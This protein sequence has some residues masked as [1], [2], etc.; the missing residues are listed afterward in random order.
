MAEVIDGRKIAENVGEE[1]IDRIKKLEEIGIIPGLAV[2]VVGDRPDTLSYVKM[3]QQKAAKLGIFFRLIQFSI[4]KVSEKELLDEIDVLNEN[5]EIHGIIVQLPLPE[6]IDKKRVTSRISVEKDVDGFHELNM[7]R[8]ALCGYTPNFIP[9]TPRG[10]CELLKQYNIN[11]EGKHVVILGKSNIVGLPMALLMMQNEATVSILNA[12]TPESLEI[13][14]IQTA[15]I[16][17][18]AVGKAFLVKKEW[19]KKGAVVIDIG[20]NPIA[21][22]SKKSGYRLVGDVDYENVK[23]KAGMITPVPGGVGPMTVIMLMKATVESCEGKCQ[24]L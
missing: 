23:D 13:N 1:L 2:I 22:L 4:D 14:L 21:D 10:V 24:K 3:K 8:L 15:D 20:I 9:C 16:V 17:I 19:I 6:H 12:L 11:V 5:P 7:G 18:S